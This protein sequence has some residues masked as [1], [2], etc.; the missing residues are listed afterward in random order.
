MNN[1]QGG[2]TQV[3][4]L[5]LVATILGAGGYYYVDLNKPKPGSE[6]PIENEYD[7]IVKYDETIATT[8]DFRN[9]TRSTPINSPEDEPINPIEVQQPPKKSV[10]EA[11]SPKNVPKAHNAFGINVFKAL[12]EDNTKKSVFIS[13]TSIAIAL[14]MVYN[15]AANETKNDMQAVLQIHNIDIETLN[16][17]TL[18]LSNELNNAD[19]NVTLNIANSIWTNHNYSV[20]QNFIDTLQKYYTAK[21]A[22]VNFSDENTNRTINVW[23]SDNTNGKIPKVVSDPL[24]PSTIMMLINAVYFKGD[25]THQFEKE[26]TEVKDFITT[27]GT[28]IKHPLMFQDRRMKYL[29]TDDFQSV[30][31]PYGKNERLSMHVFLPKNLNEFLNTLS[32]KAFSQ[33]MTQYKNKL[34]TLYLPRFKSD[35]SVGLIPA[36]SALGMS[37]AFSGSADFSG[38]ANNLHITNVFHKTYID[39][40]EEGTEAAAITG[41]MMGTTSVPPPEDRF[42]ME[43]NRPFFFAI[44]DNE[45]EAIL[46]M[47][48]INDPR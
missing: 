44:R 3:L 43:V 1:L 8:S 15:G 47:G 36:L 38:I 26:M 27:K 46:F 14:S 40:N 42:V 2:F 13:P 45:T 20:K 6:L 12:S 32:N 33:W 31:L 22:N 16:K 28:T 19:P 21:V 11:L 48:V 4:I 25:W 5:L 39:V 7:Q 18:G 9:E 23:A 35:Y 37:S 17:E 30:E 29:E 34:G 10:V 41:I 24:P